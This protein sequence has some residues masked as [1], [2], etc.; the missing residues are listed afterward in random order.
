MWTGQ[1]TVSILIEN[2]LFVDKNKKRKEK[3]TK[4]EKHSGSNSEN[5]II[6][7]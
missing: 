1:K 3:P 5:T 2:L 4:P 6:N 7:Y